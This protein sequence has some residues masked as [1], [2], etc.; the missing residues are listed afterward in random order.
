MFQ[1]LV[2]S[3]IEDISEITIWCLTNLIDDNPRYREVVV[4]HPIFD[5]IFKLF[6]KKSL[7][8]GFF[9]H[10]LE[11]VKACVKHH[12][13]YKGNEVS[14]E[15][16]IRCLDLFVNFLCENIVELRSLCLCGIYNISECDYFEEIPKLILDSGA[17]V[18]I[19]RLQDGCDNRALFWSVRIVG[20]L[21]YYDEILKELMGMKVLS[22][23]DNILTITNDSMLK[24]EVSWVVSNIVENN[25]EYSEKVMDMH[26]FTYIK[27][28]LLDP[29]KN[30]RKEASIAVANIASIED[31]YILLKLLDHDIISILAHILRNER[32]PILI[33]LALDT[34]YLLFS[35][36]SKGKENEFL[37]RF[38]EVEGIHILEDLQYFESHDVYNKA[39]DILERFY[40][41]FLESQN[42]QTILFN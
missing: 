37:R 16:L 1:R 41:K 28:F 36:D 14:K 8:L 34:L 9:R 12:K 11:F 42:A 17:V 4:Q 40:S 3:R 39:R 31:Y 23:L 7:S 6:E 10:C 29:D 32:D 35:V 38:E 21:C 5:T 30:V 27:Q 20:N 26:I 15:L 25:S 2:N 19:F 33:L 18:R 13:E 22:Y 24:R